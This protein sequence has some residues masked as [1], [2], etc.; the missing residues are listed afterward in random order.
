[1]TR[2]KKS[3]KIDVGAILKV[4][5]KKKEPSAKTPKPKKLTGRKPGSR[6]QE[7]LK[8][9]RKETKQVEVKDKRL[10]SKKPI[11]LVPVASSAVKNSNSEKLSIQSNNDALFIAPQPTEV[12][13][14]VHNQVDDKRLQQIE[15]K[16]DLGLVLSSEE[17]AYYSAKM[18]ELAE[19]AAQEVDSSDCTNMKA[20][21]RS[22]DDLWAK[23]EQVDKDVD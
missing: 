20:Q 7:A 1:M 8:Q 16:Q 15:A 17:M 14:L 9:K 11:P 19:L 6:Q 10:G 13:E 3:K 18:S 23:F 2:K 21:Q 4:A 22:D 12:P 5:I